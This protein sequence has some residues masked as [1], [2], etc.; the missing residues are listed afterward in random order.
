LQSS[1]SGEHGDG[2]V[3]GGY[4]Q[5]FFGE[6]I[7]QGFRTI[8]NLFDPEGRMNPGKMLDTPPG[9]PTC[10]SDPSTDLAIRTA[11]HYRSSGG[12]LPAVEQCK[13]VSSC[14]K[15]LSGVM[16]PSQ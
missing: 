7:Y 16:W 9:K 14:R 11:L 3:S 13:V 4:N 15:T 1:W 5:R 10:A 6:E 8:K 12:I 2:I